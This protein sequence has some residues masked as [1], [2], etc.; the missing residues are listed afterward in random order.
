[1]I[2]E[3]AIDPDLI[4]HWASNQRD[5]AEFIN[6][7]GVGTTRIPSIIQ[8]FQKWRS[9][10]LRS[11]GDLEFTEI[12]KMRLDE[13][14]SAINDSPY[15][16]RRNAKY[17]GNDTWY[18]NIIKENDNNIR[19]DFIFIN[20]KEKESNIT[21]YTFSQDD[22]YDKE[23]SGNIWNHPTQKLVPRTIKDMNEALENLLRLSNHIIFI[24]PYLGKKFSKNNKCKLLTQ[25]INNALDK[26]VSNEQV[27][28]EILFSISRCNDDVAILFRTHNL[29]YF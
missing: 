22:I 9:S 8:K 20:D 18:E 6:A 3:Y 10:I 27:N 4:L 15:I 13:L 21:E 28:I 25:L 24:D 1:M 29:K 17:D 12:D 26:S 16:R 11:S 5:Y 2:Y 14:I 23:I 7:F 19:F